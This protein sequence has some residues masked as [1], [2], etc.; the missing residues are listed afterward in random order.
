M[1]WAA[2]RGLIVLRADLRRF[3]P[4]APEFWAVAPLID[5]LIREGKTLA[6]LDVR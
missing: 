3:A 5:S 1:A 6:D 4:Q 2:A